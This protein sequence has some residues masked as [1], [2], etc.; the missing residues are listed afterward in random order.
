VISGPKVDLIS[1]NAGGIAVQNV[2]I[3]FW[4]SSSVPETFAAEL[5][6]RP[7][8]DQILHVFGP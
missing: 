2:L 5:R 1:P 6:S 7:K 3:R 4:I 8:S